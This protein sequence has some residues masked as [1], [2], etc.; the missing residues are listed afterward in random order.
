MPTALRS[1][2]SSTSNNSLIC[3]YATTL[4]RH[5]QPRPSSCRSTSHRMCIASGVLRQLSVHVRQLS[6]H[7]VARPMHQTRHAIL[8]INIPRTRL[9]TYGKLVHKIGREL[10][11]FQSIANHSNS[12]ARTTLLR[13][14]MHRQHKLPKAEPQAARDRAPAGCGGGQRRVP[15]SRRV[16]RDC[17]KPNLLQKKRKTNTL[18]HRIFL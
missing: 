1:G 6:V 10:Q 9:R 5:T 17:P 4:T 3:T 12:T 15:Q 7:V 14:C 8:P 13:P 18:C 16:K 2:S 11:R